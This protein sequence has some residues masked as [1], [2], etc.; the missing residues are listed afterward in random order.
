MKFYMKKYKH[1]SY[2]L[3]VSKNSAYVQ[4]YKVSKLITQI[5]TDRCLKY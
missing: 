1:D 2:N 4:I 5:E 3:R